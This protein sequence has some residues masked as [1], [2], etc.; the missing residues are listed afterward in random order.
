MCIC[1]DV[2]LCLYVCMCSPFTDVNFT[3]GID[4]TIMN[5]ITYNTMKNNLNVRH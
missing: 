3:N 4:E 5:D 2:L 1:V